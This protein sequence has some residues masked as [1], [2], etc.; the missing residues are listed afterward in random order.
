MIRRDANRFSEG[1]DL[2]V[3]DELGDSHVV[4]TYMRQGD[5]KKLDE[6]P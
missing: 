4:D 3:W 6:F 5:G 1:R 2:L